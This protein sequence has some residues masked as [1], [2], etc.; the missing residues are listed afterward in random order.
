MAVSSQISSLNSTWAKQ[1]LV[2]CFAFLFKLHGN[3]LVDPALKGKELQAFAK[4][5]LGVNEMQIRCR[6]D[7]LV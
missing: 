4:E 7:K 6:L 5:A 3:L 2:L 1:L